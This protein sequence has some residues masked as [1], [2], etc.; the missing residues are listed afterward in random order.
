MLEIHQSEVT[1]R[2]EID[3][4]KSPKFGNIMEKPTHCK[5]IEDDVVENE[6]NN[7]PRPCLYFNIFKPASPILSSTFICSDE[8]TKA[9]Y[10][11]NLSYLMRFS[12]KVN[13]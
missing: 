11:H 7:G 8:I 3:G 6:K 1:G 9:R 13:K 10:F 5:E 4:E 12:N 2:L